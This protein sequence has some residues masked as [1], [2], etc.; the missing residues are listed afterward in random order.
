[1]LLLTR[2]GKASGP[3]MLL[4]TSGGLPVAGASQPRPK[5]FRSKFSAAETIFGKPGSPRNVRERINRYRGSRPAAH[6][7]L[8]EDGVHLEIDN[9]GAM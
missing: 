5:I 9:L 1:V 7:V 6:P 4:P 2:K 3:M 8:G